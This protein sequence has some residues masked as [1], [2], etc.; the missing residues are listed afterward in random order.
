MKTTAA[1]A[2]WLLKLRQFGAELLGTATLIMFGCGSVA[3]AVLS[4]NKNGD[5]LSINIGWGLGVLMGVLV[6]GPISG[7]HLNPAVTVSLAAVRK[8]PASSIPHFLLAQYLGAFLGSAIVLATYRDALVHFT[9]GGEWSVTGENATA[10]IFVTFPAEGV[11]NLGG[12]VDQ[13]VGTMLL[14][15]AIS[16]INNP[17]NKSVAAA[18]GPLLVALAVVAIGICF[19]HNAGY[20]INPARDL[21]PRVMISLLGW[22][23]AAFTAHSH[24]WWIPVL[25]CHLGGL[26]GVSIH[27]L[28]LEQR[29]KQPTETEE[30]IINN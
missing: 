28:L 11:T 18:L 15:L 26:L 16:A 2:A 27:W 10:G 13:V 9:G 8:F 29:Q 30:T 6:A 19:G 20:A 14:L 17:G 5:M 1:R 22:G 4:R 24:W 25:A 23:G 12:A 7:A 21:G 3:Q